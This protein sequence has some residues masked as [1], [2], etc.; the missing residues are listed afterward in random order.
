MNS[1]G[2]NR[3]IA[4]P[5]PM[6]F[7]PQINR[8]DTRLELEHEHLWPQTITSRD[9]NAVKDVLLYDQYGNRCPMSELWTN[10]K[11]IIIFI[12][13]YIYMHLR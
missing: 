5:V 11:T 6:D 4:P 2:Q 13:V 10:F 9:L 8:I 1:D 7:M 12:R 3:M